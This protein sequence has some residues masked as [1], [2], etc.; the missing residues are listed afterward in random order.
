MGVIKLILNVLCQSF[1]DA[2]FCSCKQ[3]VMPQLTQAGVLVQ[4]ANAVII[5]CID[6]PYMPE[7]QINAG[8]LIQCTV[9]RPLLAWLQLAR[10]GNMQ[11]L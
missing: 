6:L 10:H 3:R 1:S 4:L 2:A 8:M 9:P 7:S 5:W 11:Y